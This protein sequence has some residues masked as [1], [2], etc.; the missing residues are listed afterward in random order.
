[1]LGPHLLRSSLE[2]R[3]GCFYFLCKVGPELLE[4]VDLFGECLR[5]DS[6]AVEFGFYRLTV[7]H[8]GVVRAPRDTGASGKGSDTQHPGCQDVDLHTLARCLI[9]LFPAR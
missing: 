8:S 3:R 2:C 1:M 7:S 4:F 9:M 5:L 6:N